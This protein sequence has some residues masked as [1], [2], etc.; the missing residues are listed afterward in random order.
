MILKNKHLF[1]KL[2]AV[3]IFCLLSSTWYNLSAQEA[4]TDLSDLE[5]WS[6]VAVEY[7]LTD[8]LS[9]ELEEQFR[10]H[11]DISTIRQAYTELALQYKAWKF[12]DFKFQYRYS[13]NKNSRNDRRFAF[14][15]NY[16]YDIPNNP[17]DIGYRVRLQDTKEQWTERRINYLR[18][19]LELD[20]NLTK[21]V[22]PYVSLE[23]FYQFQKLETR[24]Y[25]FSIGLQW[26]LDGDL[27]LNTYFRRDRETNVT[28]PELQ[29]IIG[30][31]LKYDIN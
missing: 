12:L 20:V 10:F 13:I 24:T 29:Y 19:K 31:E 17:I 26:K 18:N 27:E 1:I 23:H 4:D 22:D 3:L 8:D 9:V 7:E 6:G 2:Q 25:R 28:L 14:D 11:E 30:T 15:T 21:L 5:L 16:E